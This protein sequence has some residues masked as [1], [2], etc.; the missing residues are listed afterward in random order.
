MNIKIIT[1]TLAQR[2]NSVKGNNIQGCWRKKI[3]PLAYVTQP[4]LHP[5]VRANFP[6]FARK[7]LQ[8]TRSNAGISTWFVY[9]SPL[10]R[11]EKKRLIFYIWGGGLSL[12]LL[13]I[14]IILGELSLPLQSGHPYTS[15]FPFI[16]ASFFWCIWASHSLQITIQL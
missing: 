3:F 16:S 14:I 15:A 8:F 2:R 4:L 12:S 9:T 11:A 6:V 1:W 13:T 5:N 7:I 10:V